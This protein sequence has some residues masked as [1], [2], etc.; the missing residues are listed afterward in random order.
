VTEP[1]LYERVLARIAAGQ[2]ELPPPPRVRPSAGVVPWRRR[3]DG[4][5]EVFW[6][7]R[8]ATMPFMGGFWAFPGGGLDRDD[9]RIQVRGSPI[10]IEAAPAGAALPE[11]VRGQI[12]LGPIVAPGLLAAAIRELFEETGIL[13]VEPEPPVE[14]LAE[15]RRALLDKERGFSSLLEQLGGRATAARLVYAGRWLTPPFQPQRF[16]NRFFLLEWPS[17]E[18]VQPVVDPGE[19]DAGEWIRPADAL[20]RWQR[21]QA[22]TAPPI[23]H[24]LRVLAEDGPETGL[25]RLWE[26]EE[27]NLGPY[28]AIEFR[29]GV[30]L[31]PLLTPTLPPAQFTNSY[32]I[33]R[34]RA[35]LVDPGSP[36]PRQIEGLVAAL[37]AAR[38]RLGR[39]TTAIWLTHHHPDHVGGATALRERLGVPVLAH[40]QTARLLAGRGIEVDGTLEAGQVTDLGGATPSPVRVLHT[41]GHAPGHLAFYDE[42]LG[43]LLCGDLVSGISTI[44]VD[45]P[46]GDMDLYLDSLA[47]MRDLAPRALFPA[48]GPAIA[49]AVGTLQ[50][51]IDHRLWREERILA[52]WRSGLR[53]PAAMLPTVYDDVPPVA[54]PLAE[55]QAL[56]HLERLRRHG[57]L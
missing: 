55:R 53:E 32:L 54:H 39:E 12:E 49:D 6:L 26:P 40:E 15:A 38:E 52:A 16:D 4:E 31:F 43:S 10:G 28:R 17:G 9:Q 29:P 42:T 25:R 21:G 44:V 1:S 57:R 24:M 22:L 14:R 37:A 3:P 18:A 41:P 33:G 46:L 30:L 45:P 51:T 47:R 56:A 8:A 48:H 13:L 50:E 23:L 2:G 34:G 5:V 11:A 7:R 19:S 35:A 27:A 36:D 20:E